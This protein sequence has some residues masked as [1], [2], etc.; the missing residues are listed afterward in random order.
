MPPS[1]APS[2]CNNHRLRR[3]FGKEVTTQRL[4]SDDP[5]VRRL[6]AVSIG[7]L[8]PEL[9]KAHIASLEQLLRDQDETVRRAA[10][11]TI[12]KCTEEERATLMAKIVWILRR[13]ES[14]AV[15]EAALLVMASASPRELTRPAIAALRRV[16]AEEAVPLIDLRAELLRRSPDGFSQNGLYWDDLHPSRAGHQLI[17]AALLPSVRAALGQRPPAETP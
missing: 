2:G 12:G 9:R 6:S 17:S 10:C 14:E 8:Q 11:E 13:D 3:W 1:A 5:K 4:S 7:E 15:R 16:A